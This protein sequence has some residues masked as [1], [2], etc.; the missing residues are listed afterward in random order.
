MSRS[1]R[2]KKKI[3]LNTSLCKLLGIIS[4]QEYNTILNHISSR[5]N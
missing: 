5:E 4:D 3:L 2:T 1:K